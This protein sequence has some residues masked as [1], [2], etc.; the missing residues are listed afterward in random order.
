MRGGVQDKAA[1][2]GAA[3]RESPNF[4]DI[5]IIWALQGASRRQ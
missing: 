1:D 3:G 5:Y 2:R 4:E